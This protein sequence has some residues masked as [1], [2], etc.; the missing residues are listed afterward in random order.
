MGVCGRRAR[1]RGASRPRGN[2]CDRREPICAPSEPRG[3]KADATLA[4]QS[5][6]RLRELS[7]LSFTSTGALGSTPSRSHTGASYSFC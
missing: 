5:A 2:E 4:A 7:R 1:P 3:V 6:L